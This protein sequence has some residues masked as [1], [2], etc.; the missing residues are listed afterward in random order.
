V[1]HDTTS[2]KSVQQ[3]KAVL[4]QVATL[5]LYTVSRVLMRHLTSQAGQ[6]GRKPALLVTSGG[7]YKQPYHGY[8]SLSLA[9]AAQFSLTQSLAQAYS[10]E[11]VHVAAVVVHGLVSPESEHFSPKRIAE[12]FWGLYQQGPKGERE[13]WVTDGKEKL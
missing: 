13:V 4:S 9:K 12:V 6:A 11:G 7:L 10:R 8:F 1:T 5:S 3:L 2:I